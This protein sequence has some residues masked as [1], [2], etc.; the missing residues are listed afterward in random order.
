MDCSASS[1]VSPIPHFTP[2]N[3][4]LDRTNYQFWRAHVLSTVRAHGF[5]SILFGDCPVPEA[6]ITSTSE[7]TSTTSINPAYVLWMRRDQFLLSWMLA[8]IG[9]SM[10]GHVSRCTTTSALWSVLEKLFQTSSKARILQIR[11]MLQTLKKCDMS[12]DDYILKMRSFADDL[13]SV[14]QHITDE[15]LLRLQNQVA[16]T[17]VALHAATTSLQ[18][19]N[20]NVM[21]NPRH[22]SGRGRGFRGRGGFRACGNQCYRLFDISFQGIET[23]PTSSSG[24]GSP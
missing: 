19:P 1:I 11:F 23:P 10:L 17:Q 13:N 5:E 6:S 7:G 12:I 8:S 9:E 21:F 14:G 22:N 15:E 4:R 3:L 16:S 20:A 24:T 2:M 18:S